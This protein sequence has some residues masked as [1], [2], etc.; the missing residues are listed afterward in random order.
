MPN[1]YVVFEA[2]KLEWL[3]IEALFIIEKELSASLTR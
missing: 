3:T 2:E 1:D